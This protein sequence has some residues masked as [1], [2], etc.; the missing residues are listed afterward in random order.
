MK[1]P[2]FDYPKIA[3]EHERQILEAISSVTSRGAYILQSELEDFEKN[4]AKLNGT[5]F[6]IGVGNATDGL[7]II[8]SYLD[9]PKE[10]E[11]I[12]S[13]HT[14]VATA[15]P[16]IQSGLVPVLC[17]VDKDGLI[18]LDQAESLINKNTVAICPTHLNGVVVDIRKLSALKEKYDLRIV[19]D[20]A[21][22]L[23]A[24]D[25]NMEAPGSC[26]VGGAISF[27]LQKFL[28]VS[29]MAAQL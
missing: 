7:E 2:F 9:L 20:A 24:L 29:V 12:V 3:I 26:D 21:Q 23:G 4:I 6:A 5:K 8:W 15:T 11:V 19:E 16:I 25:A 27:I 17:D 1:V 18:D 28:V 14:M 13:A 10:G 22:A